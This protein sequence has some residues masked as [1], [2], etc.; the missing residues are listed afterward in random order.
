MSRWW[1]MWL[2]L[3]HRETVCPVASNQPLLSCERAQVAHQLSVVLVQTFLYERLL[4]SG[5]QPAGGLII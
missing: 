1:E 4:T 5:T 3:T 2:Q